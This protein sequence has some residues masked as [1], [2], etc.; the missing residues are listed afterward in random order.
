MRKAAFPWIL[1]SS[2]G[3]RLHQVSGHASQC[4][5]VEGL[6][7]VVT[8]LICWSSQKS[9]IQVR[10]AFNQPFLNNHVPDFG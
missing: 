8:P 2:L 9:G 4:I 7:G 3:L 5:I 10:V 6:I 1:E